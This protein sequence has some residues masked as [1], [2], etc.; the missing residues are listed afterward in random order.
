MPGSLPAAPRVL[1]L[2]METQ[3]SA[4]EV[5]GWDQME[6]MGLAVAVAQD[7]ASGEVRVYLEDEVDVFCA[8]LFAAEPIIG[9]NV[10]RFDFAVLRG[11]R[12]WTTRPCRPWT[13]WRRSTRPSAF[14]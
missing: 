9:F 6:R 5:G 2:D 7:L 8:D 3:R 10:R 11:Y 13:S 12:T 1:V 4:E 14:G